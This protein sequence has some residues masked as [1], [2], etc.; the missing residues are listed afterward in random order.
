VGGEVADAELAAGGDDAAPGQGHLR[1]D[2]AIC[3]EPTGQRR[4]D[5]RETFRP[6]SR[7]V[8][9]LPDARRVA[10]PQII[11]RNHAPA[12]LY[13]SD[14]QHGWRDQWGQAYLHTLKGLDARIE[15]AGEE[16]GGHAAR[17]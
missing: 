3:L 15:R 4:V 8:K 12:H 9:P 13:W 2:H 16:S 6:G 14:P 17:P 11:E 5:Q 7:V 10:A 1:I